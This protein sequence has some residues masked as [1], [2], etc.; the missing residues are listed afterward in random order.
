M[1]RRKPKRRYL[2]IWHAGIKDIESAEIL[3][4]RCADLFGRV[5]L[6]KA[7]LRQ[8]RSIGDRIVLSVNLSQL[9]PV[10]VSISL[11]HPP[12]VVLD[13][14][15]SLRQLEQRIRQSEHPSTVMS[16]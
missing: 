7:S 5:T 4:R 14:S 1:L 9:H 2:L 11:C 3:R 16:S 12:M 10:L 6:E 15:G 13:M 8:M